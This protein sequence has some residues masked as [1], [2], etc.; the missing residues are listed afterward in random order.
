MSSDLEINELIKRYTPD[1]ILVVI[2][3]HLKN[4][5]LPTEAY[6]AV[7]EIH[8]VNFCFTLNVYSGRNCQHAHL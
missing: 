7:E 1:P 2:D 5:G 3:V 6:I 8:D 4:L